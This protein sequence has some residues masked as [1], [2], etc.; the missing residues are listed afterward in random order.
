MTNGLHCSVRVMSMNGHTIRTDKGCEGPLLV[1]LVL[2]FVNWVSMCVREYARVCVC[3]FVQVNLEAAG[4]CTCK[5][6]HTC[7]SQ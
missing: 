2:L 5:S 4:I 7:M 3:M 6:S 1:V